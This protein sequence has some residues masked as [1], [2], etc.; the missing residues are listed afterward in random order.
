MHAPILATSPDT[1]GAMEHH[2]A[3]P[4]QHLPIFAADAEILHQ[5]VSRHHVELF[6]LFWVFFLKVFEH[7]ENV[8]FLIS[9]HTVLVDQRNTYIPLTTY[10]RSGSRGTSKISSR[11]PQ[12]TK[13]I[14][15]CYILPTK[16]HTARVVAWPVLLKCNP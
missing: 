6:Q 10:P 14:Q 13:N 9:H 7:L 11:Y 2:L 5:D 16:T 15:Q 1:S 3:F 8:S 12:V 4:L